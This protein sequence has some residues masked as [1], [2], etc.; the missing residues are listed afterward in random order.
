LER[1]D[2]LPVTGGRLENGRALKSRGRHHYVEPRTKVD[3]RSTTRTAH[4][5]SQDRT[6]PLS[7]RSDL[8]RRNRTTWL[9]PGG[10]SQDT[11]KRT[12]ESN[13]EMRRRSTHR[14][15][16]TR[17]RHQF[18]GGLRGSSKSRL[19]VQRDVPKQVSST[20]SRG[21]QG[22]NIHSDTPRQI[23]PLRLELAMWFCSCR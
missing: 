16:R 2:E 12:D 10:D 9:R 6:S 8:T 13:H 7:I 20:A 18:K 5:T 21:R 4:T 22:T 15:H 17:V 23:N 1:F 19:L 3:C 11:Q 14:F